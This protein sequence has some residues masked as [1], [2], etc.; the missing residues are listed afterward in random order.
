MDKVRTMKVCG[1]K[2][3]Y[4]RKWRR[5]IRRR[6]GGWVGIMFITARNFL[7]EPNWSER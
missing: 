4:A 7:L 6:R 3:M 1:R 5:L 2:L